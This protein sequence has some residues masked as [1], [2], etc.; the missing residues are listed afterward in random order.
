MYARL[1]RLV[2]RIASADCF[3]LFTLFCSQRTDDDSHYDSRITILAPGS[4]NPMHRLDHGL[5]A[6]RERLPDFKDIGRQVTQK[7]GL[8]IVQVESR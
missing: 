3:A 4:D 6:M 1:V 7:V 2:S 5:G 8:H